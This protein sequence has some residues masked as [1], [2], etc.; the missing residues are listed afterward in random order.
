MCWSEYIPDFISGVATILA[1]LL[2]V[3]GGIWGFFR[4]KEY[5]MVRQRYLEGG[6]DKLAEDSDQLLRVFWSNWSRCLSLLKQF[7]HLGSNLDKHYYAADGFQSIT[8]ETL[9]VRPNYKVHLLVRNDIFHEVQQLAHSFVTNANKFFIEDLC[10]AIKIRIEGAQGIEVRVSD[11]EI[12]DRYMAKMQE[13]QGNVQRYYKLIQHLENIAAVLE[14]EKLNFAALER[15]PQHPVVQS[16][17]T[18]LKREFEPDLVDY[19]MS[20]APS[21]NNGVKPPPATGGF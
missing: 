20:Q 12:A 1:A 19:R 17:I 16:A 6:I 11:E 14:K 15:F 4:Q 13:Y 8:R 10:T 18:D 3:G 9:S 5:E 2:A 7:R 21:T